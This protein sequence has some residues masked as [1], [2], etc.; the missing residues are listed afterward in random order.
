MDQMKEPAKHLPFPWP[1]RGT[2]VFCS[3]P[4]AEPPMRRRVRKYMESWLCASSMSTNNTRGEARFAAQYAKQH[5]L[6]SLMIVPGRPQ[7]DSCPLASG[8]VLLGKDRRRPSLRAAPRLPGAM[9]FMSGE[10][11]WK[12]CSS[13]EGVDRVR[14]APA[15]DR[16]SPRPRRPSNAGTHRRPVEDAVAEV[17]F[18]AGL[19]HVVGIEDSWSVVR[20]GLCILERPALRHALKH[21]NAG[22]PT[23]RTL[24][25]DWGDRQS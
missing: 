24:R 2:P 17:P 10:D 1:R 18:A 5:H 4:A 23:Q 22:R 19:D 12:P 3:F 11:S 8:T 15:G 7:D 21:Y 13:V 14:T 16:P 20:R 9:C 25:S 6:N